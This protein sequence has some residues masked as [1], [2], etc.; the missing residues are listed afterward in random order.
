MTEKRHSSRRESLPGM[1]FGTELDSPCASPTASLF[2][3]VAL[4]HLLL[5]VLCFAAFW[6]H[7]ALLFIGLDGANMLTHAGLQFQWTKPAVGFSAT[8]FQG[9]TSIWFNFNAWLSPGLHAS[10]SRFRRG[11]H[12][13]AVVSS[14]Y[15]YGELTLA[16]FGD[17]CLLSV[18]GNDLVCRSRRGVGQHYVNN[19]GFLVRHCFTQFSSCNPISRLRS[20]QLISL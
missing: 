20:Q 12:G 3:L 9:L 6:W 5:C 1:V 10:L 11:E 13:G 14:E 18:P 16:V 2:S 7:G 17:T 19:A 15:L 8:P 4:H